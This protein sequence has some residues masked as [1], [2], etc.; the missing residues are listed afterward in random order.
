MYEL[1][2]MDW[3]VNRVWTGRSLWVRPEGLPGLGLKS[4]ETLGSEDPIELWPGKAYVL[5]VVFWG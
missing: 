1:Y 4:L 5:Y 3:K 2:V